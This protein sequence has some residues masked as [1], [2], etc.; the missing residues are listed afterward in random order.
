MVAVASYC[1][2]PYEA[3]VV[4]LDG[5]GQEKP[6]SPYETVEGLTVRAKSVQGEVPQAYLSRPE[7]AGA[8]ANAAKRLCTA[9]EFV[10]ACNGGV[11]CRLYPHCR[12]R[13]GAR[14]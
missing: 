7:A 6:H 4:E 9:D 10:R 11:P 12:Q 3:Y 13:N 5:Q 14:S 2:D 8:C 1:I